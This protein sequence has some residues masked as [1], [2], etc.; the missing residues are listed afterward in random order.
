MIYF[1]VR[2]RTNILTELN[3]GKL[4]LKIKFFVKE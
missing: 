4:L 3:Q 1:I 2:Y